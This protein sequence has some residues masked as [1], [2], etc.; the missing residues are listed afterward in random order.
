[1]ATDT[2]WSPSV[3]PSDRVG[4][5]V[6]PGGPSQAVQV[7][8]PATAARPVPRVVTSVKVTMRLFCLPWAGGVSENLYSQWNGLFPSCIEVWP[9]PIPGRGRRAKDTP[10]ELV[11]DLAQHLIETLPFDDELP[12]AIF[13]TCLGAIVGYEMIQRLERAGR[14]PPV[15]F[16]PA[17]VS[18]PDVYSS[19][20]TDIYNPDRSLRA[21]LGL[22]KKDAGLRDRVLERLRSWRSLPKDEVLYAF[23]AGHFAGIEEMK[24]STELFDQVAPMAV[25]DIIMA[26]R[27][28]STSLVMRPY[29]PTLALTGRT[30]FARSQVRLSRRHQRAR[31]LPNHR[32]RWRPGQYHPHRIHE[33]ASRTRPTSART[34]PTLSL[35]LR[36]SL[37]RVGTGTLQSRS[38]G[39]WS[40][41][42]TTSSRPTACSWPRCARTRACGRSPRSGKAP[43]TRPGWCRRIGR[44]WYRRYWPLRCRGFFWPW[45]W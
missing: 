11:G 30:R 38:S 17:A 1:L 36:A 5:Y 44:L 43:T 14:K 20:I 10:L 3:T 8:E 40:T 41:A 4:P 31:F 9:V 32:I 2:P 28:V 37:N 45:W 26:C 16:F 29:A 27:W 35:P 18:P 23:E 7:V 34:P 15:L 21:L 42:T 6:E 12:Y 33:G 13:G 39:S 22:K 19:V 24:R 25:N